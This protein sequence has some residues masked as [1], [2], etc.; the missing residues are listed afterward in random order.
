[1]GFSVECNVN[2]NSVSQILKDHGLDDNG[3][4]VQHLRNTVD[5]LSDAYIPMDSGTLKNT[6]YYPNAYSIKYISPYAH[7]TYK[8]EL[9]LSPTGSSWAKLGE[10]KHYAGKSLKF[11]QAPKRGANWD[12]RLVAERG[13]DIAQDLQNFIDKGATSV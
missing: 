11:R 13:N 6:K 5:R 4:V 3:R 1:M 9:M 10:K 8:G 2:I 12:K 7:Y